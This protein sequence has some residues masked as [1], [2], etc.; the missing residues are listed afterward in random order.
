M[1]CFSEMSSVLVVILCLLFDLRIL[2]FSD[3]PVSLG[4]VLIT[5]FFVQALFVSHRALGQV[6]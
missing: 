6:G 3:V 2:C 4:D 1:S 5:C